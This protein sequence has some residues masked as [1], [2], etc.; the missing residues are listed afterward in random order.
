MDLNELPAWIAS[1]LLLMALAG[2]VYA[3]LA[4]WLVDR[5]AAR[6]SPAL[7]AD[8]PRPGVTILKDRK[9]V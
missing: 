2:C 7:A 5:F 4:A 1:V 9:H 3:L 6:P 8:A